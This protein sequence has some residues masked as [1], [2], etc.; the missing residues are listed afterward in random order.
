MWN[1]C[2]YFLLPIIFLT[3]H[4]VFIR[5]YIY[6]CASDGILGYFSSYLTTASPICIFIL[7]LIEKTDVGVDCSKNGFYISYPK[8]DT[9]S[10]VIQSDSDVSTICNYTNIGLFLIKGNKNYY[11]STADNI[12]YDCLK[13]IVNE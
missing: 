10:I 2:K 3:F 13:N 9:F 7:S 1:F 8:N 12:G 4:W 11:C 6:Y 5:L